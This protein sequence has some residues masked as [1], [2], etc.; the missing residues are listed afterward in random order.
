LGLAS[1]APFLAPA[2][3]NE[4]DQLEFKVRVFASARHPRVTTFTIS[5]APIWIPWSSRE[6]EGARLKRA[7]RFFFDPCGGEVVAVIENHA[8]ATRVRARSGDRG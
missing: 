5:P 6:G 2:L 8:S 4:V 1:S 3:I 7:P